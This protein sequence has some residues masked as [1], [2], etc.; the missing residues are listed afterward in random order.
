M[1]AANDKPIIVIGSGGHAK[2]II[3]TIRAAGGQVQAVLDDDPKKWETTVLGVPVRS[4][5]ERSRDFEHCRVVVGIG[6]ARARKNVVDQLDVEFPVVVHPNSFVDPTAQLGPG[7]VVFA[8]AVIQPGARVGAHA[9]INSGATVDHDCRIGDYVQVAPGANVCGNVTV[10]EGTFVGAG[11]A[12]IEN[13]SIGE[14]SIIGAASA[15][16]QNV[17]DGVVAVGCPARVVKRV[18]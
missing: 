3:S 7:T 8:G 1:T 14:W 15:V 17:P 18:S 2:V 6:S 11:A 13:L 12:V 5:A 4:S 10:G 16:V 9:I